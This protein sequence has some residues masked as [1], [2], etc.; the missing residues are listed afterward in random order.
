MAMAWALRSL[1][2]RYFFVFLLLLVGA[3]T[4][5]YGLIGNGALRVRSQTAEAYYDRSCISGTNPYCYGKWGTPISAPATAVTLPF[6][7][8]GKSYSFPQTPT[9][10]L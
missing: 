10:V 7:P 6:C 8:T 4:I 3:F 2:I 1:I 5:L 9:N